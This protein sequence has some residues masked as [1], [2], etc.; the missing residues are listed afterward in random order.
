[1]QNQGYEIRNINGKNVFVKNIV[2]NF[3][4]FNDVFAYL[5]NDTQ[6]TDELID[7]LLE[8][9]NDIIFPY[10]GA[11]DGYV[12]I[13]G[14]HDDGTYYMFESNLAHLIDADIVKMAKAVYDE[15]RDWAK[16]FV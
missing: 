10:K 8:K 7:G 13:E 6:V 5:H 4:L 14:K 9:K 3:W 16:V 15:Y 11:E 2:D 1:M 12:L